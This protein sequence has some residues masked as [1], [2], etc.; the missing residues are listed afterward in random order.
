[1][2]VSNTPLPSLLPLLPAIPEHDRLWLEVVCEANCQNRRLWTRQIRSQLRDKLPRNYEPAVIDRRLI[3]SNHEQMT[4]LGIIAITR[5]EHLPEKGDEVIRVIQ[6][7]VLDQPEVERVEISD[8]A[9]RC[10][11]PAN[12]IGLLC[13]FLYLSAKPFQ[14]YGSKTPGY[15]GA[16]FITFDRY[17]SDS[18]MQFTSLRNILLTELEAKADA[19]VEDDVSESK[20]STALQVLIVHYLL[21]GYGVESTEF[22]TETARLVQFLT[23]K[24]GG[25]KRIQDTNIYKKVRQPFKRNDKTVLKDLQVIRPFFVDLGLEKVVELIDHECKTTQSQRPKK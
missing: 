16:E 13:H 18:L 21:K 12:E 11:L 6:D 23:G 7:I 4:L 9:N 22:L 8:I 3:Q 15:F 20:T 5:N 24:E 2:S 19:T 10:D 25:V 14:S 1:M 17:N